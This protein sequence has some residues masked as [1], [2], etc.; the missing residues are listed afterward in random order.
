MIAIAEMVRV[1]A[2]LKTP[3]DRRDR[4]PLYAA[5]DPPA[6]G[7]CPT[8]ASHSGAPAPGVPRSRRRRSLALDQ[9][10]SSGSAVP[11]QDFQ[12]SANQLVSARFDS[13]QVERLDDDDA[14]AKQRHVNRISR[15]LRS[16]RFDGEV[17][18]PDEFDPVRDT[19]ACRARVQGGEVPRERRAGIRPASAV[20]CLEQEPL[21]SVRDLRPI[22]L[23]T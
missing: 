12:W 11:V 4:N 15:F 18:D 17:V 21:C 5:A 2:P 22:E 9:E 10:H 19:P 6:F 23:I 14:S 13:T 1:E 8:G 3:T 7:R 20:P 16:L